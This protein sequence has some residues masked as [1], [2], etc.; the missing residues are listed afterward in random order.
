MTRIRSFVFPVGDE[1]VVPLD[2]VHILDLSQEG[3]IKP[4]VDA[5]RFCGRI[6]GGLSLMSSSV[7]RLISEKDKSLILD[8]WL[9]QRSLY[10]MKDT[11][12]Y[13]F[14]HAVLGQQESKFNDIPVPRGRRIS[15]IL[16]CHPRQQ[17]FKDD[18]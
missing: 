14:A 17:D 6:I 11:S 12:R 8:I 2:H 1:E 4:H 7:M 13:D 15:V 18:Q 3:E 16:R 10:I 5:V 9:K